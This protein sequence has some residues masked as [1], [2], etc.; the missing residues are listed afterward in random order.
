M[1]S[2]S[3][4]FFSR[5]CSS[6]SGLGPAGGVIQFRR[7]DRDGVL[8]L[9]EQIL[10]VDDVAE[11]LVFAVEPVRAADRLEQTVIL[12]RLVDVEIGAGRRVEAGQQLVHD[13]QQ[14]HV[15]R[16]L[17][18]QRLGP[19]LVG[20]GLGHARLGID[21]LQQ[22][23]VGVVDELLVGFG[24]RA[25][26]FQRDVLGLR[27]VRR[28]D[29]ALALERRLL[30]QLEILAGL[31]DAGRHQHGVAALAGQ[32]RLDAE[33]EDDVADDAL[34]ARSRTEH[35]L[36]RAP[37]LFQFVLLPVVQPLGLGLEPCVDLVLRAK[38]LVDVAGLV[39]QVE[40]DLVLDRLAELVGVDVA[41]KDL[42]AGLLVLLQQRRAG[43]ADEDGIRHDRLHQLVQP[44]A[45][46]AVAFVDEHEH[47]ADRRARLGFQF[48]D[49]RLELLVGLLALA[50]GRPNLWTSEHSSRG[51]ACA[52]L[53]SSDRGRCCCV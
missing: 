26:L 17:R 31:V 46:R 28:D 27:I 45:L 40:H 6:T 33:I 35:V 47:L 2:R 15:G 34:H 23:G 49:E 11:I 18:E 21:I 19:F 37:L 8:D 7:V 14:P 41:A 32:S 10:V 53:R 52:K 50:S 38:P 9:L 20:L 3:L 25:G 42:Q 24:V 30:E 13:D 22:F 44:A 16:L 29:G 36:H 48:L 5:S 39:D 4:P 1:S 12:H 43:E 51:V